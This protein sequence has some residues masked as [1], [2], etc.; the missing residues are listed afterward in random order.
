MNSSAKA[1]RLTWWNSAPF[2]FGA[3]WTDWSPN[4][5]TPKGLSFQVNFNLPKA[6]NQYLPYPCVCIR[7]KFRSKWLSLNPVP[8]VQSPEYYSHTSSSLPHP[9]PA[10]CSMFYHIYFPCRIPLNSRPF[11]VKISPDCLQLRK[12]KRG[13]VDIKLPGE[14]AK[15]SLQK[16]GQL[17][18]F[19]SVV[20]CSPLNINTYSDWNNDF[21]SL[22][23]SVKFRKKKE[24]LIIF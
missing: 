10:P 5:H 16:L 15:F 7:S 23:K 4:S 24:F 17:D 18:E 14:L 20:F 3:K 13:P 19:Y 9:P 2:I 22:F 12:A 11:S 21:C 6:V 8:R 1:S